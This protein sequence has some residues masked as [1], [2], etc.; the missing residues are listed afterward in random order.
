MN[1]MLVAVMARGFDKDRPRTNYLELKLGV[2]DG[3]LI[4]ASLAVT[5][6][7]LAF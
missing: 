5:V 3:V 2:L 4:L 7:N 1:E 6:W